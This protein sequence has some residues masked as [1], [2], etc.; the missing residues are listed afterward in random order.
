MPVALNCVVVVGAICELV[1]VTEIDTRTAVVT[2]SVVLPLTAP[3]VALIV[4]VPT[5]WLLA[6]PVVGLTVATFVAVEAQVAWLVTFCV[7]VSEY[8]PVAVNCC[9]VPSAI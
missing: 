2:V 8:V 1:G 4:V 3:T 6:R 5:P 7:V 9:V